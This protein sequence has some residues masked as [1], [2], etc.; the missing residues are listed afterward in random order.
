[1]SS[2]MKNL[3]RDTYVEDMFWESGTSSMFQSLRL[4]AIKGVRTFEQRYQKM[5]H[6][7]C[8]L[9]NL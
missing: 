2:T 3:V 6:N 9:A 5:S 4:S 8:L 7:V 1:M